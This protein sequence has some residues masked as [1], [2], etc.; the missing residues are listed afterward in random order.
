MPMTAFMGVRSSWL[1]LAMNWD[2]A[3]APASAASFAF[4]SSFSACFRAMAAPIEAAE[5]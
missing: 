2:L 5:E 3:K 1:M 4:L